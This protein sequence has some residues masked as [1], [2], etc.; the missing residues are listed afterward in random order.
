MK[1]YNI[2]HF[3]F[4]CINK[5]ER[6]QWIF[7]PAEDWNISVVYFYL[8]RKREIYALFFQVTSSS[9]ETGVSRHNGS[10]IK[11][12]TKPFNTIVLWWYEGF[13][14]ALNFSPM[15]PRDA[16]ILFCPVCTDTT[17]RKCFNFWGFSLLVFLSFF[18]FCFWTEWNYGG[19]KGNS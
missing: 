12:P 3:I 14:G 10:P 15:M 16:S 13:Q 19:A 9:W 1:N 7:A 2:T 6:I 5:I 11:G 8:L 17:K 18:S 4:N